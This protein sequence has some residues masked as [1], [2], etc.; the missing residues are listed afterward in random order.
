MLLGMSDKKIKVVED[1]SAKKG[2]IPAMLG[3]NSKFTAATGWKPVIPFEET[4]GDVLDYWRHKQYDSFIC[5]PF[6]PLRVG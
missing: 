2:D 4:L 3:D 6:L 5:L 1:N